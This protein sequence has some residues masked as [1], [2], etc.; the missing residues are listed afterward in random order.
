MKEGAILKD[1]VLAYL[2][3]KKNGFYIDATAGYGYLSEAILGM[4]DANGKL[5]MID[6]DEDV[7][8]HLGQKEIFRDSRVMIENGSYTDIPSIT[9][10]LRLGKAEGAL[11]DFGIGT[12][13]INSGRGFSFFKDEPLDMRYSRKNTLLA[14]EVINTYPEEKIADIIYRFGE[15]RDSRKIARSIIRARE[16]QS[17]ETTGRLSGIVCAAKKAGRNSS[18]RRR[19]PATKTFQALRIFVNGEMENVSSVFGFLPD[20]MASSGRAVFLSYHSIEDRIVKNALVKLEKGAAVKI[21]TKKPVLA[22][23][24]E[25]LK[26]PRASSAK[27]RAAEFL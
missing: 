20:V 16:R 15:E 3:I 12:Y 26:Q 7:C 10:R 11:F 21:L 27:L 13:Q 18:R 19:H 22:G 23:S 9:A 5:L 14:R 25:R 8:E 4:L 1:E 6:A 17:I 24:I 2:N